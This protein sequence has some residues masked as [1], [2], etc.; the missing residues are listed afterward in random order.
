M[1]SSAIMDNFTTL[2]A[3]VFKLLKVNC[4]VV[5]STCFEVTL[6]D[7]IAFRVSKQKALI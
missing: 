7:F 5:Y 6:S 3:T 2:S 4:L 1:Q